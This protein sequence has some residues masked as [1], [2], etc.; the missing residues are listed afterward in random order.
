MRPNVHLTPFL[1]RSQFTRLALLSKGLAA[2]R[3]AARLGYAEQQREVLR[4][5]L[6]QKRT[7]PT[8]IRLRLLRE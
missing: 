8:A 7:L 6:K 5:L 3:Y 1:R 2:D 4:R